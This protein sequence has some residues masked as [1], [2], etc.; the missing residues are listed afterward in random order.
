MDGCH[1]KWQLIW[2]RYTYMYN[3]LKKWR[4]ST[5]C[6]Q[7]LSPNKTRLRIIKGRGREKEREREREKE[8]ETERERLRNWKPSSTPLSSPASFEFNASSFPSIKFSSPS[9]C[10]KSLPNH[11]RW[12]AKWKAQLEYVHNTFTFLHIWCRFVCSVGAYQQS[13]CIGALL[14]VY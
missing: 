9:S 7:T 6:I 4:D 13:F 11:Q 1:K 5:V 8:R 3:T 12:H 2:P 14:E 10:S